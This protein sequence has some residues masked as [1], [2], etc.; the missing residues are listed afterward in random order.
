MVYKKVFDKGLKP[1]TKRR[2]GMIDKHSQTIRFF[3]PKVEPR[4]AAMA[5]LGRNAN[6]WKEWKNKFGGTLDELMRQ[7]TD[8]EADGDASDRK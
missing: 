7:E 8:S 3:L 4:S 6:G 1:R 5:I 2:Q